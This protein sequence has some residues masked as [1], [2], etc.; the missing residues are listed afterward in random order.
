MRTGFRRS[1]SGG[2]CQDSE[3][4]IFMEEKQVYFVKDGEKARV[5]YSIDELNAA[6]FR[7]FDKAV[8]VE[9]FNA[10]GCY[11]R[12]L[13]GEIVVGRTSGE[14]EKEEML[15]EIQAV[16]DE[17][18]A[19]DYRALKAFKLGADLDALYPGEREWYQEKI[20]RV[21]ELE[22]LLGA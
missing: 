8:S 6:G 3:E 18:A 12:I 15:N 16:K 10:N 20:T 13:D 14:R 9:A 17:I 1:Y 21:N 11:T 19:R 7:K 22:T 2:G 5:F 4:E